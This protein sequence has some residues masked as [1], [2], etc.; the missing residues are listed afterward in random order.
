MSLYDKLAIG[1][2]AIEMKKMYLNKNN[3]YNFGIGDLFR[4]IER[5][6]I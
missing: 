4:R 6:T 1:M 3:K 2:K 5:V